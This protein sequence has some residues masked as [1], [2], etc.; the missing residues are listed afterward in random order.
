MQTT[1]NQGRYFR[2][3]QKKG[4]S[5][6]WVWRSLGVILLVVIL[7][8]GSLYLIMWQTASDPPAEGQVAGL[9]GE[10]TIRLDDEGIPFITA[11][12][13]AD[14]FT[15]LGYLHA[16][17]RMF[18]MELVRR[19][20]AGRLSEWFGEQAAGLDERQRTL[21]FY[22]MA[23]QDLKSLDPETSR[24]LEAYVAGINQWI[25]ERKFHSPEFM[26]LM[27]RPDH[28]K[29]V[30]CLSILVYQTWFSHSL[31]D[32]DPTWQ[33]L[34][35]ILG[36]DIIPSLT[37][38][39]PWEKTTLGM[40]QTLPGLAGVL[41]GPMTRAS[42]SWVTSP[43]KSASGAAMHASDPHLPVASVP[44]FWYL[45]RMDTRDGLSVTGVTAPGLPLIA[46]GKSKVAAW[47]FT[48]ASLDIL[49]YYRFRQPSGDSLSILGPDGAEPLIL[50][51]DSVLVNG[52]DHP[53]LFTVR[54]TPVGPVLSQDSLG[55]IAIRWA[56]FDFSPAQMMKHALSL[57]DVTD[58]SSFR[59]AVTGFGALDVNWIYSDSA[60]HI[61]YQ[62]GTPVP[63]REKSVL[64]F[65]LL[66]GANRD[67]RWKGYLNPEA[68][69][70]QLDPETG[71]LASCNNRIVGPGYPHDLPGYYD[72]YRYLRIS[73]LL[74]QDTVF[75]SGDFH[76]FQSDSVSS[77]AV[78]WK[79][80]LSEGLR[81]AGE[82]VWADRI[83]QWNG[84]AGRDSQ[85][86]TLFNQWWVELKRQLLEDSLGDEWKAGREAIN[87]LL[88]RPV[89]VV[90]DDSRTPE[91]E[92]LNDLSAT[93]AK[94]VLA[95]GPVPVWGSVSLLE[96][97]HPLS[98]VPGLDVFLGLNRG[99]FALSGDG[100]SLNA[101]FSHFD[102]ERGVFLTD[103][104][105]SMRFVLDWST[106]DSFSIIGNLGQSGNP[107]SD[108]YDNWLDNWLS[109]KGHVVG[110]SPGTTRLAFRLVPVR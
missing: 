81:Q 20:V 97:N 25:G 99:P 83:D 105:P 60:G 1:N 77:R 45:V 90:T 51:T 57:P 85:E 101:S 62:L 33:K 4:G 72:P 30:D 44:G 12:T 65:T 54:S 100:S 38:P 84:T 96:I 95:G 58:F 80:L 71:W 9:S 26:V 28:W 56:G 3:L 108:L 76:R 24:L 15:A 64:A 104:A 6:K 37:Q 74:A 11:D 68:T 48:V 7:A 8:G 59:K 47:S 17:H 78:Q 2:Y 10:V 55:L 82:P 39:L 70:H 87:Q 50:R 43:V 67:H 34:V 29:P 63:V 16:H 75:T 66:D 35:E 21:G 103:A 46:M 5:M 53:R 36:P 86:A 18:Q 19:L 107:F 14:A 42:N 110:A 49:D 93:A 89:S 73:Q 41:P 69:P 79:S 106:P 61:G 31:M 109:G 52:E 88:S 22:H 92:S 98:V 13:R 27:T 91:A 40:I 23:A 94:K 102:E 32:D